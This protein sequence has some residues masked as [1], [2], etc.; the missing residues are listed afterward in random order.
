MF[1]YDF[2]WIY[3]GWVSLSFLNLQVYICCQIWEVFSHFLKWLH[4]LKYFLYPTLFFFFRMV[5]QSL[6]T[7]VLDTLLVSYR[8]VRLCSFSFLSIFSLYNSDRKNSTALSSSLLIIF[9]VKS[10]LLLSL[11]SKFLL[12]FS[13]CLF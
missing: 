6:M 5:E 1:Q 9:S 2:L 13:Y 7:Q 10:Y 12:F 11:Q 3:S 8:F 4:F